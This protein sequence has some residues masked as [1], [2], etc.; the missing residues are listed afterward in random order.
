M[1]KAEFLVKC[2]CFSVFR[3]GFQTVTLCGDLFKN[4]VYEL[5]SEA[6]PAE[7]FLNIYFFDP[8][9]LAARFLRVSVG[10]NAVADG[11]PL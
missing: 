2:G 10:K 6:V 11:L 7:F 3:F 9:D 1:F 4:M 8:Y 5:R